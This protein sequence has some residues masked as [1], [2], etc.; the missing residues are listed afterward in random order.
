LQV[1]LIDK[2][3]GKKIN[4]YFP[5]VTLFYTDLLILYSPMGPD[6]N[7]GSCRI[8]PSTPTNHTSWLTSQLMASIC[9]L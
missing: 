4:F 3:S 6:T 7:N 5:G 2:E 8:F 9:P 1:I